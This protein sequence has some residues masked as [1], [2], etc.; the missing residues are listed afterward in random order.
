MVVSRHQA[1]VNYDGTGFKVLTADGDGHHNLKWLENNT[2][3]DRWSR[4]DLP[5]KGAIRDEY[6][7]KIG[8]LEVNSTVHDNITIPERFNT[9][10]RDGT[11]QIYGIIVKP[12]HF[13]SSKKYRVIENIYSGP[14]KQVYL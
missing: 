10:G 2:F 11:T 7:E 9:A 5:L 6:G 12:R 3:E 14:T 1:R 13:N 8:T 4:V